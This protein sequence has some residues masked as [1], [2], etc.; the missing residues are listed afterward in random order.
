MEFA[1]IVLAAGAGSRMGTPKALLRTPDGEPWSARAVRLLLEGGCSRVVVV[2]G[3][4]AQEAL[5]LVPA[6][7]RVG[8]LVA[9]RWDEGLSVSLRGGLRW[10]ERLSPQPDAAV[11]TLVDLPGLTPAVVRRLTVNPGEDTLR[12]AEYD[13]RPGHPVVVGRAHWSAMGATLRGDEGGRRY[14][15]ANGAERVECGRLADGRDVDTPQDE[16]PPAGF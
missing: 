2:L 5:P 9:A 10:V 7:P 8:T 11:V 16:L 4:R 6:D 14:L 12:Q 13:G 15:S 1:G 3:A